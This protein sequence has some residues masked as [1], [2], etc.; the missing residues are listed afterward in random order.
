M[1]CNTQE[2]H[3]VIDK[4]FLTNCLQTFLQTPVVVIYNNIE[5]RINAIT[6]NGNKNRV[7]SY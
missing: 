2:R 3:L 4:N 1:Y 6:I 7:Y 5:I